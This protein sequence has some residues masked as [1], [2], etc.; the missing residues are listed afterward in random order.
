MP[1]FAQNFQSQCLEFYYQ[2][3]SDNAG[4]L[5]I[6][7]WLST[8]S[9]PSTTN[10]ERTGNTAGVWNRGIFTI[11]P[12]S[13]SYKVSFEAIVGIDE[14]AFI[15]IDDIT[16]SDG[17]CPV[18]NFTCTFEEG[19]CSI[20][21][22]QTDDVD[23]YRSQGYSNIVYSSPSVDHTLGTDKGYYVVIEAVF[24]TVDDVAR[25]ITPTLRGVADGSPQACLT[26]FYHMFGPGVGELKVY[27]VPLGTDMG[28]PAWVLSGNRGDTW[29]GAEVDII[30]DTDFT[31][32]FE[33]VRGITY[34]GDIA[35]DDLS[36]QR[37]DQCPGH[38]TPPSDDK[39]ATCDFEEVEICG[40]EQDQ[41]DDVD[42]IWQNRAGLW[43]NAGPEYDHT[44][45]DEFGFYLFL[46]G[47][48][49]H[50]LT[51]R[52]ISPVIPSQASQACLD[53]WWHLYG[54]D[55]QK[56]SVY[57]VK[58]GEGI[59]ETPLLSISGNHGDQWRRSLYQI[60]IELT[61][62]RLI[63]EGT[64][65]IHMRDDIAI[66]DV[67]VLEGQQCPENPTVL[68]TTLPPSTSNVDCN[69]ESTS[70]AMCGWTQSIR[71]GFDWILH[72]GPTKSY[73]SGPDVDH[74]LQTDKGH[75]MLIDSYEDLPANTRAVISSPLISPATNIRCFK[76][77]YFMDGLNSNFL[78]IFLVPYGYTQ[79]NDPNIQ[80]Y[81]NMGSQWMEGQMTVPSSTRSFYIIVEG[82]IGQYSYSADVAVDDFSLGNGI[83]TGSPLPNYPF[84]ANCNFEDGICGY[85]QPNEDDTNEDDFDWF[86]NS[87]PT[88]TDG[89]GPSAD[90]TK[91][92]A[93][94]QYLYLEAS[95]PRRPGDQAQL[96]SPVIDYFNTTYCLVF[97]YHMSGDDTGSLTVV[98]RGDYYPDEEIARLTGPAGT[99]WKPYN[100]DVGIKYGPVE[101]VFTGVVGNGYRGDIALD[102]IT[103]TPGLCSSRSDTEIICNFENGFSD[104]CSMQQDTNDQLDWALY[105]ASTGDTPPIDWP[106]H[107][108]FIY[109]D[110]TNRSSGDAAEL[111]SPVVTNSL[112]NICIRFLYAL[113]GDMS[114]DVIRVGGDGAEKT[115]LSYAKPTGMTSVKYL[116]EST[117]FRDDYWFYIKATVGNGNGDLVVLDNLYAIDDLCGSYPGSEGSDSDSSGMAV[118]VILGIF[119]LIAVILIVMG[120]HQYRNTSSKSTGLFAS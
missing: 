17:S 32:V 118:C 69:F 10:W 72:S 94:G 82:A 11:D 77:W 106:G 71:D 20:V 65:G 18:E 50:R 15:A 47:D 102:D 26:F 6:Y 75:Y 107:G 52:M 64:T 48:V 92:T 115:L 60:P 108:S 51:A 95:Q 111:K 73:N 43:I 28:D 113:Q 66:D 44:T 97:F 68:P 96:I 79:S 7:H 23:W 90:H 116:V 104:R 93:D 100:V 86:L 39:Q 30:L 12:Q 41:S 3:S 54:N 117:G 61:P 2:I 81:G 8:T 25:L 98:H 99:G 105:D 85:T 34:I 29:R 38:H 24:M 56:L 83:C 89:S 31:I 120:I 112:N 4:Q 27:V 37:G 40:Y 35:L 110:G 21:Q 46:Y 53:F 49:G 19:M 59:P 9:M 87:G 88:G 103:L 33:A 5:N 45:Q 58:D 70:D 78:N 76:F 101:I 67:S 1:N 36:F 22:D 13:D 84:V 55:E 62:C 109:V 57:C 91:G 14:R 16:I 63:F 74:T 119:L 80:L 114:L 42:W